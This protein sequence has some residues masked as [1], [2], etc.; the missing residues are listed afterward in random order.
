M[1]RQDYRFI[2]IYIANGHRTKTFISFGV[3]VCRV[4]IP[5]DKATTLVF[6]YCKKKI[7]E[8]IDPIEDIKI[9][10]FDIED[11]KTSLYY[12]LK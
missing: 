12:F 5:L 9:S 1:P 7:R 4:C 10:Y 2:F 3:P 6:Q 8:G 11:I